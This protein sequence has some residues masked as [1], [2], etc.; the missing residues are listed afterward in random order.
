ML[1]QDE[2][3]NDKR[4]NKVKK[5]ID[6]HEGFTI[7]L[8]IEYEEC[9]GIVNHGFPSV[10]DDTGVIKDKNQWITECRSLFNSA[11][12]VARADTVDMNETGE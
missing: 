11:L 9:K 1:L 2:I 8:K 3:L 4:I 12:S 7:E 6:T 5:Q 10:V